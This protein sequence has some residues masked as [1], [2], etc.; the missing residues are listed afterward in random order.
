MPTASTTRRAVARV[1]SSRIA[2]N[3]VAFRR[4]RGDA[5]VAALDV[6]VGLQLLVGDPAKLVRRGAVAG[7]EGVDLFGP[8][9][10]RRAG[11]AQQHALAPAAEHEGGAQPR[12]AA[13]DDEDVVGHIAPGRCAV[14]TADPGD[15]AEA[16]EPA[17]AREVE[18]VSHRPRS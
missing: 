8:G 12:R 4:D 13:A 14:N 1:P 5:D 6:R 2:T 16:G 17:S 18:S 7:D 3:A 9:V 10:A 15:G 11:V